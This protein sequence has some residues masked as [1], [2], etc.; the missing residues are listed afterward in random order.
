M[1][2]SIFS[3]TSTINY[4]TAHV[5]TKMCTTYQTHYARCKRKDLRR[6]PRGDLPCI[7][8]YVEKCR[9]AQKT[10][11]ICV[12]PTIRS[13][14][15][16]FKCSEHEGPSSQEREKSIREKK[17]QGKENQVWVKKVIGEVNGMGHYV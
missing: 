6:G 8:E 4:S 5:H 12:A 1:T 13:R 9:K 15:I 14:W 7:D 17:R 16:D 3:L 10:E 2:L 11:E